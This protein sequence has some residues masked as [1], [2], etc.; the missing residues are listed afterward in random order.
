MANEV[1]VK[2]KE[3]IAS[4]LASEAVHKNIAGVM[5]EASVN[6][7]ASSLV[8]A[9]QTNPALQD[10]TNNSLLSVALVGHSLKLPPSPQLGYYYFVPYENT[11]KD[12][13]GNEYTVKEATFQM[14]YRGYIQLALRSGDYKKIHVTDIK[15]GE[16]I[17]YDPITDEFE[18]KAIKDYDERKQRDT[19]GYYAFFILSNGNK[20]ELYWSKEKME[21]HAIKYSATYRS[22]KKWVKDKS[23]WTTNFDDMAYKTLLRQLISKWGIMSTE[24]AT[25]YQSD[26]SVLD[27]NGTPNY[28]DNVPDPPEKAVDISEPIDVVATEIDEATEGVNFA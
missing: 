25:A 24:M 21:A 7:F 26:M 14:S 12:A 28:V 18:F 22:T 10:C 4:Y 2:K 11:K 16:L 17:S 20:K 13:N 1:A 27:E 19:V 6:A 23:L 3:G 9:V 5:G 15:E 8:S